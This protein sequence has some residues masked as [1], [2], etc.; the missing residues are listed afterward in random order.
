MIRDN[1]GETERGTGNVCPSD[2]HFCDP[3]DGWK[4]HSSREK[5]RSSG[6]GGTRNYLFTW[7]R[8][9]RDLVL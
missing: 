9:Q 7:Q 3:S 1:K 2:A 5:K 8:D 6:I 4:I